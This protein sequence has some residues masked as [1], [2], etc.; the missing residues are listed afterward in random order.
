MS[1]IHELIHNPELPQAT[2]TALI[3]IAVKTK[4]V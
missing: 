4:C 3:T 2:F 1:L